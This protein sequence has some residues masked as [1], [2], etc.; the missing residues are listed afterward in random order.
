[1][2]VRS[3]AFVGGLVGGILGMLSVLRVFGVLRVFDLLRMFGVLRMHGGAR[4]L[5]LRALRHRCGMQ[6]LQRQAAHQKD[7]QKFAPERKHASYANA[8]I[9]AAPTMI[10]AAPP[11]SNCRVHAPMCKRMRV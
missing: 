5:V 6:T 7:N 4:R 10:C 2:M 3:A 11:V 1:M 9:A 8:K